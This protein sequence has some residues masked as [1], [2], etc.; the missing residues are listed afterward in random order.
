MRRFNLFPSPLPKVKLALVE[1]AGEHSALEICVCS[2][3][4][5]NFLCCNL[6]YFL[7]FCLL[8]P[9][10]FSSI[11]TLLR[12]YLKTSLRLFFAQSSLDWRKS[13]S[14]L[15]VKKK[16]YQKL[17]SELLWKNKLFYHFHHHITR[18]C[19]G[20]SLWHNMTNIWQIMSIVRLIRPWLGHSSE[21]GIH[22]DVMSAFA[23]TLNQQKLKKLR[24]ASENRMA[25]DKQSHGCCSRNS[26]VHL[27][28]LPEM[29]VC[30]F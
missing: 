1:T 15:H 21:S 4:C 8:C 10:I 7:P 6:N 25:K 27:S 30:G 26:S 5:L 14:I 19:L 20:R 29:G 11:F 2:M 23:P 28:W 24:L 17:Q 12:W 9:W 22:V 16:K 3:F 18:I 13:S